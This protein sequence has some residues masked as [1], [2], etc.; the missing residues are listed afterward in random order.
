M[1]FSG[2][3]GTAKTTVARLLSKILK[4]EDAIESGR[5]VECGRQDLVGKYV[6]WTAHIVEEKFK[7]AMGGI[8]FIDE[9]YA[10]VDD[11]NT[12]GAEAINCITQM[13][14]NYR[15]DV[16]VIFAGYLQRP[17]IPGFLHYVYLWGFFFLAIIDNR[18]NQ[19]KII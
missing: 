9:A 19:N 1:M 10:L 6:G 5:F 2:N 17:I 16:I 18:I 7:E 3:P 12:Y 4:D 14:E 8:L 15:N 13:M 11:S